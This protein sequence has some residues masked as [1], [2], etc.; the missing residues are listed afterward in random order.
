MFAVFIFHCTRFFCTE[1]WHLKT[2][3]RATLLRQW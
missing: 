1:G 2:L 3:S